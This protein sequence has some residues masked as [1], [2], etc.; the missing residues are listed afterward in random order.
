MENATAT[1]DEF[2][3]LD[4]RIGTITAAE[5]VPDS[6]KLIKLSVD[7]GVYTRQ[8]VS[9]IAKGYPPETLIG[10]QAVFI[11]NLEPR[12]LAGVESQGMILATDAHDL[13]V[14]IQPDK[15]VQSGAQI[16]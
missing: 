9:G 3:K 7:F 12:T 15:E 16:H 11:V 1:Y 8:I 2:A 14:L 6:K 5:M 4:L 13:P 10:K